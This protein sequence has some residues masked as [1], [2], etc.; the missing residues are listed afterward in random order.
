MA[1]WENALVSKTSQNGGTEELIAH[2]IQANHFSQKDNKEVFVFIVDH[3]KRYKSHPSFDLIREKFPNYKWE[4]IADPLEVVKDNFIVEVKYAASVEAFRELAHILRDNNPD[5]IT[6]IDELFLDKAKD[7]AKIVPSSHISRFSDMEDRIKL[8]RKMKEEG[9]TVGI[10]YGIETLDKMTLGLLSHQYV[11]IA[12]WTGVGKSTLGVVL[13]VNHY[14]EGFT[15]MIISLEMGADELYRKLDS[16]CVGMRQHALKGLSLTGKEIE[17]WEKYAEKVEKAKND[18][19]IV[20]VDSA[21]PEKIYAETA[22][23]N[24]D[25]VVV[26]YIQLLDAGKNY[27]NI[28]EKISECSRDMKKMARQLDIPV[29][30]L[31]QTTGEEGG[32]GSLAGSKDIGKHSDLVLN[33]FQDQ[34]MEESNKME[35]RVDKNRGGPRGNFHMYWNQEKSIF[36]EWTRQDAF[37]ELDIEV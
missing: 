11:T 32:L 28:W 21:T 3:L 17:R 19:I 12:G 37:P 31:A 23:W 26:D 20:D 30:G 16:I 9:I 18:I 7:L 6:R 13:S 29:Y 25:V 2:G 34:E 14:I 4:V 10:P 8:Y 22:R 33:L 35:I 27:K 5:D 36:R 1:N 15:P 24:P